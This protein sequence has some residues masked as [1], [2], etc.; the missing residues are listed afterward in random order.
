MNRKGSKANVTGFDEERPA[1]AWRDPDI[2][3]SLGVVQDSSPFGVLPLTFAS[4]GS[5]A[6]YPGFLFPVTP[7]VTQKMDWSL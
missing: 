7:R 4:L 6:D 5:T 2:R 3:E 1:F